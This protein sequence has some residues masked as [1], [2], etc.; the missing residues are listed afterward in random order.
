MENCVYIISKQPIIFCLINPASI[1]FYKHSFG[2]REQGFTQKCV[3]WEFFKTT[4]LFFFHES[5]DVDLVAFFPVI[6]WEKITITIQKL[7]NNC[8]NYINPLGVLGMLCLKTRL[9]SNKSQF[10]ARRNSFIKYCVF[11]IFFLEAQNW[12]RPLH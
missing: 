8:F 7:Q 9:C 11:T 4:S 3:L 6:S 5:G 10:N 1:F 2:F 12:I